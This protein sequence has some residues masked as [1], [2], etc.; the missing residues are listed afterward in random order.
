MR[1]RWW[2][3]FMVL[4]FALAACSSAAP[5]TPVGETPGPAAA[6]A[7]QIPDQTRS[8]H[9]VDSYPSHGQTL[10][11]P[12]E[13]IVV[14]FDFNLHEDSYISVARDGVPV[15]VGKANIDSTQLTMRTALGGQTGDGLYVVT[16][17][18]C[19]P[20]RSCHDG[21]FAF[22]VDSETAS[23]R[24]MTGKEAVSVEMVG[25]A[26]A[27]ANIVVSK[28]TMVTWTN[29]EGAVH[30]VNSDPHPSHNAMAELNSGA[31]GEGESHSYTFTRAGEWGYHCS[32]HYP[33]GMSG[34]VIVLD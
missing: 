20:D 30:F 6:P 18:A 29:K 15:A 27:P 32:A 13:E 25:L 9:F 34:R 3:I 28:G 4:T 23:Y 8:P 1:H 26:F 14:N 33:Q 22:T 7:M 24:D 16:Y 10:R 21:Q 5:P 12:P 19:W 2:A 31:L 11:Q 17:R